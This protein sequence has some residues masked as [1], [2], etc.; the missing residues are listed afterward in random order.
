M[1]EDWVSLSVAARE[2]KVSL[3]K[4]SR[5]VKEG[6]LQSARDPR[7]ERLVLVNLEEVRAMFPPRKFRR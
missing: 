2:V 4:L 1:G 7:D 3:S 6:R 5:L